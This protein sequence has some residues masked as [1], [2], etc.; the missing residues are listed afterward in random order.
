MYG[1]G[2][3]QESRET[4]TDIMQALS[5]AEQTIDSR[6]FGIY[7]NELGPIFKDYALI[8]GGINYKYSHKK[9]EN[10]EYVKVIENSGHYWNIPVEKISFS[11]AAAVEIDMEGVKIIGK[12]G[13]K[14][15]EIL[16]KKPSGI[17]SLST[18]FIALPQP[19]MKLL[20]QI[21]NRHGDADCKL[22][23]LK[24]HALYCKN[25]Q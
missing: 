22:V 23:D 21:I 5:S 4:N 14:F 25:L 12:S 7:V 10:V 17:L 18:S 20:I 16:V 6:V 9:M 1:G 11:I 13:E 3:S 15:N 19:E 2:G 24:Y 8:L